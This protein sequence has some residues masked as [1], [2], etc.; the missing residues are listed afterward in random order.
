MSDTPI[1]AAIVD[2]GM[3]NLFSVARSCELAG[4]TPEITDDPAQLHTADLVIL[5]GVGAFGDAMEALRARGLDRA[6]V[7][8]AAAGRPLWGI[9]LGLQL[10]MDVSHEMGEHRGL[11]IIPGTVER[12]PQHQETGRAW[13]KVPKVGWSPVDAPA[14]GDWAGTPLDIL[15]AGTWFYF[16]HSY[17]AVPADRSVIVAETR[18]VPGDDA[19][20]YCAAV[21]SGQVF[22]TQFHP[23]RSGAEGQRIY[24]RME[25]LVRERR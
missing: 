10:L 23:E 3:G 7:E 4:M 25:A 2:F 13:P 8:V 16:V 5:P 20:T 9:C 19:S 18:L 24:A 11:G 6:L 17:R 21:R 14:G 1:R 15:H 22:A 12:L